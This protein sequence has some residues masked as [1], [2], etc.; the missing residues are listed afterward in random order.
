MALIYKEG[1]FSY[2]PKVPKQKLFLV[3]DLN[4]Y[5]QVVFLLI[6]ISV[7]IFCKAGVSIFL[8]DF[9]SHADA[10]GHLVVTRSKSDGHLVAYI[11]CTSRVKVTIS[12]S[13]AQR[14]AATF[15]RHLSTN[16]E[17]ICKK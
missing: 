7:L 5:I 4:Q 11:G 2:F 10:P 3:H 13:P 16:L 1:A 6:Y 9:G 14:C 17:L 12:R 8:S 15:A